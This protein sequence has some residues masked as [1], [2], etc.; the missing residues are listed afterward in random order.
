MNNKGFA[1]TSIIYG[2]MLLFIVI[3]TSFLSILVGR[4]RRMDI[5]MDSVY[6]SIYSEVSIDQSAFDNDNNSYVTQKRSLYRFNI[7]GNMCNTFLPKNTV[8]VLGS[9]KDYSDSSV[10]NKLY[11]KVGGSEEVDDYKEVICLN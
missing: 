1:I 10:A 2:L 8:L 9:F 6:D 5:L 4:N 7:N 3:I 11:F